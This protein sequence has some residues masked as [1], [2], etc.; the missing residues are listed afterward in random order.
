MAWE[1]WQSLSPEEKERY[2]KQARGFAERGKKTLDEQRR[3]AP[4]AQ[5]AALVSGGLYFFV[6]ATA[7][8][9]CVIGGM[10]AHRTEAAVPALRSADRRCQ[11]AAAGTAS[12][13][14][15]LRGRFAAP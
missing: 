15:E 2:K 13:R 6:L 10:F 5:L 4:A 7:L 3:R 9:L 11:R 8:G 14:C 12:T 1:R